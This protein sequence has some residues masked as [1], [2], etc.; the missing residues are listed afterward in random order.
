LITVI[1]HCGSLVQ[2]SVHLKTP[3]SWIF[4]PKMKYAHSGSARTRSYI[5]W[6]CE[7]K[8]SASLGSI[9][10]LTCKMKASLGMGDGEALEDEEGEDKDGGEKR[11]RSAAGSD[12]F[13]NLPALC[14]QRHHTSPIKYPYVRRYHVYERRC[15]CSCPVGRT[16]RVPMWLAQLCKAVG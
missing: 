11:Y 5:D 4:C 15:R 12:H 1:N 7:R 9:V 3:G 2:P 6:K 16:R 10:T 8:A 13:Y 14:L